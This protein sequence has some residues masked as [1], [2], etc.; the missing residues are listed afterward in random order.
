M[1]CGGARRIYDQFTD[2]LRDTNWAGNIFAS[3]SLSPLSDELASELLALQV[4]LLLH[5][6]AS[7]YRRVVRKCE[8]CLI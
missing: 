1:I 4:E 3:D 7:Y 6:A 2:G 5:A 8:Q